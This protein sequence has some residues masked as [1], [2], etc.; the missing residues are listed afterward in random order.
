MGIAT[1]AFIK[2]DKPISDIIA[3]FYY[4]ERK[5]LYVFNHLRNSVKN[6]KICL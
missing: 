5:N 6:V 2:Q 4:S 1:E 3:V